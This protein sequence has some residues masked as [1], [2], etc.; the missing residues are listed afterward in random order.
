MRYSLKLEE[1]ISDKLTLLLC[2]L[3]LI[4]RVILPNLNGTS[5]QNVRRLEC[6]CTCMSLHM[7]GNLKEEKPSL[8]TQYRSKLKESC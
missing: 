3:P 8:I 5:Q 6:L 1:F 4:I 2:S 7:K